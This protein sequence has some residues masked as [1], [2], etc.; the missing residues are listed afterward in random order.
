[1]YAT[2]NFPMAEKSQLIDYYVM[3]NRTFAERLNSAIESDPDLTAAGLA[4]KADLDNS[5][6][7]QLLSGKAQNPRMDTA[8]K[9]C[10][11]MGTTIEEFMGVSR[12]PVQAEILDLYTKLS[13]QER[14]TL[15]SAVKG[16]VSE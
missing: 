11:A 12:D 13:E 15:L 10:R 5:T 14:R 9:I 16:I 4:R 8:M 6:I 7:R 1:M 3:S 2:E